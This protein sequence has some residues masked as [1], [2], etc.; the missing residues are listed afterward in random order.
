MHEHHYV[1]SSLLFS[2]SLR[3]IICRHKRTMRQLQLYSLG[4]LLTSARHGIDR[5]PSHRCR[6]G[7]VYCDKAQSR[8]MPWRMWFSGLATAVCRSV[9]PETI[10]SRTSRAGSRGESISSF[11]SSRRRCVA[12]RCLRLSRGGRTKMTELWFTSCAETH[13]HKRLLS[14]VGRP[15]MFSLPLLSCGLIR[16]VMSQSRS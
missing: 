15:V 12:T 5:S 4:R 6:P 10:V 3:A 13:T 16:Y 2:C 1:I 9:D 7:V 11:R 14:R 8:Q